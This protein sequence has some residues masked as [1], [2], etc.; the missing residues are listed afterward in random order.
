ML[1]F[2]ARRAVAGVESVEGPTYSRSVRLAGGT[3]GVRV[4][5]RTDGGFDAR[6]LLTRSEDLHEAIAALPGP[7]RPRHRH[8]ADRGHARRRP[9][10]RRAGARGAGPAGG[11]DGRSRTS[12]RLARCSGSRSRSARRRR[13]R[14]GWSRPAASRFRRRPDRSRICFR[15][16]R[17]SRRV[18]PARWR[19]RESRRSALLGL[20]GALAGGELAPVA[21]RR[22]R[23]RAARD[24]GHR[25]LDRRL[26]LDASAPRPRRLPGHRPRHPARARRARRA[27]RS[28]RGRRAL[29][30]VPCLRRPAPVVDADGVASPAELDRRRHRWSSD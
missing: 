17:R 30:T 13:W 22:G 10:D 25:P 6:F 14:L 11:R 1:E 3:G 24:P 23:A 7:A 4:D 26:C 28:R 20:A 18:D 16:P 8:G 12:S 2:F 27:S 19:C 9:A 15:P 29:A 5:R 21:I